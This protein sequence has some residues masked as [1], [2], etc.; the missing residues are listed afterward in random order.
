[1]ECLYSALSETMRQNYFKSD[2]IFSVELSF[3]SDEG[4]AGDLHNLQIL[5]PNVQISSCSVPIS[6]GNA[7]RQTMSLAVIDDGVSDIITFNLDNGLT[8]LY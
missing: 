5:I 8:E 6:D 1:L 4:G 3:T 7:I 2:A